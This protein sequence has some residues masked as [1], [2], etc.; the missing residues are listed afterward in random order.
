[1]DLITISMP[2][3]NVEKCVERAL[4]SALNQSYENLEFIIV[5]DKG[6]D[7]SIEIVKDIILKHPRGRYV[8]IIEHDCNRGTGA[9]KNTAIKNAKGRFLY[10]MDSDDEISSDCIYKLYEEIYRTKVDVVSGSYK[11]ITPINT[12]DCSMQQTVEINKESII[13]SF[14][15]GRF[16]VYTWNK[17][18]DLDFLKKF[19]IA[20]VDNQTIEDNYFT[21]QVLLHA[22]SYSIIPDITYSYILRAT[23]STTGNLWSIKVFEQWYDIFV[24]QLILLK[25]SKLSIQ[26]KR[27]VLKKLFWLRVSVSERAISDLYDYEKYINAYL[28][29][30]LNVFYLNNSGVLYLSYLLSKSPY[31]IKIIFLKLHMLLS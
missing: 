17:L 27:K 20:C 30:Q 4:L 21:F 18:Y 19:N 23:S 25:K 11:K 24:D 14:F 26:L 6:N 3:Y 16:P 5:D 8:R 1:M 2:I 31:W 9:T 28:G 13:L 22:R 7:N 15:D 29:K 10:F 12:I